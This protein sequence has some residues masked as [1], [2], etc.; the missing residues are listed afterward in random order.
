MSLTYKL[1]KFM[2]DEEMSLLQFL[3][4]N[5]VFS[6]LILSNVITFAPLILHPFEH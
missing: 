1:H 3:N 5:S 4:P 6:N 2:I